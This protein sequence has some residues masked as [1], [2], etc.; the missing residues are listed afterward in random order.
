MTEQQKEIGRR[1]FLKAVA[2]LPPAAALAWNAKSLEPIRAG[3][4]G[5]GLQGRVLLE[6]APPR[7]IRITAVADIFPPNLQKALETA[8]ALHDPAAI[9]Y[10]DYKQLLARPDIEAVLIAVPLWMHAQV[11]LDAI[12]AGKHVLVEKMVA[13]TADEGRQMIAAARRAHVNLQIGHQRAYNPLYHEA[14]ELVRNGTI[15]DVHHVRAVWHRN[16][17]W[18][19]KIPDVKFDP[20]PFGYPDMEHYVN[21]RL[22]RRY[23]QGLLSELCC[24]QIHAINWFLAG[25]PTS[26]MGTGG[27]HR[28]ADGRERNDHEYA[29]FEY[30]GKVTVTWSSIQSNAFD[31]YYEE[32]MGTKGTVILTGEKD[33]MLFTEG[34]AAFAPTQIAVAPAT[35]GPMLEASE[36]RSRDA[37]GSSVAGAGSQTSVSAYR[38]EIE[39]FCR[40][41]RNGDANLCTGEDALRAAVP[42]MKAGEA[43]A[44]RGRVEIPPAASP[45]LS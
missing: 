4:I 19:R 37:A 27:I 9:G 6:N 17:D 24:H 38:L 40:T 20:T 42:I 29:I 36:S 14:R 12:S 23:S 34:Q 44:A 16:G 35:A 26:V 30:P 5:P 43:I 45:A 25:A 22:Y 11:V 33:A 39:G 32:F 15:G 18:R 2:T 10:A 31:H 21:W 8:R 41:I 3:L 1:N 7:F 28:Y 13:Y